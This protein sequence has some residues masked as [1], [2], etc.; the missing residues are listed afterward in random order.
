VNISVVN[1]FT[2]K[3]AGTEKSEMLKMK[4]STKEVIRA[5]FI[6]GRVILKI[7]LRKPVIIKP[8]SSKR[9][10]IFTKA[11]PVI[12]I[13]SGVKTEVNTRINPVYED[14]KVVFPDNK[15]KKSFQA[16]ARM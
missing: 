15:K 13:D 4:T 5:G 6:N 9:E 1:T 11:L 8:D 12:S 3:N 14:I 10:L 16:T 2:P 7:T